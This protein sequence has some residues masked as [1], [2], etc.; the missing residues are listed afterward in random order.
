MSNNNAIYHYR[1]QSVHTYSTKTRPIWLFPSSSRGMTFIV[2]SG[3]EDVLYT[4][5]YHR[6]QVFSSAR[7]KIPRGTPSVGA[8]NTQGWET[9]IFDRN[10]RLFRKYYEID[11]R[12]ILCITNTKSKFADRSVSVPMISSDLERRDA[13]CQIFLA[14]LCNYARMLWRK[15]TEFGVVAL[16]QITGITYFR[17]LVTPPPKGA[18][19]SVPQIGGRINIQ[20]CGFRIGSCTW[21]SWRPTS[22]PALLT[23][24]SATASITNILRDQPV[25]RD[26]ASGSEAVWLFLAGVAETLLRRSGR[27]QGSELSLEWGRRGEARRVESGGRVLAEGQPTPP[28]Q[29]GSLW[30]RCKLP[31]LGAPA[32]EG[33][34]CILCRQIAFPASQ[35]VLHTACMARYRY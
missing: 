15:M 18:E 8:L 13:R 10:R 6:S 2:Y 29:L 14:D 30:E 11:P 32:A 21:L 26:T 33:F 16:T 9:A 5:T 17:G 24:H 12:P 4:F 3:T 1:P 34:S 31:Q 35:Y 28:H 19:P 20:S 22:V 27:M 25:E 7:Y 23:N